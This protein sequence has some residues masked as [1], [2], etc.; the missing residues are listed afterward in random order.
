MFFLKTADRMLKR[1]AT[2][3]ISLIKLRKVHSK[4][5]QSLI[6]IEINVSKFY[7]TLKE[8]FKVLSNFEGYFKTSV[9][10]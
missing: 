3:L 5:L 4:L 2:F 10:L 7:Q 1:F 8:Y 6:K 9:K